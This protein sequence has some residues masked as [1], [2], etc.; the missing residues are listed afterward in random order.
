MNLE[1]LERDLWNAADN[2]RANSSLNA[3]QYAMPVLGLI[4]LRH[5]YNR[6]LAVKAEIEPTLPKRGG[7]P[8]GIT[9]GDFIGK[10]AIYLP[11]EAHYVH[12]IA[13]PEGP[14]LAEAVVT[15]MQ[16]IEKLNPTLAGVLP[17]EYRSFEPRVLAVLL[18][19]FNSDNLKQASGNVLAGSTSTS[20]TSLPRPA[21]RK[22]ASSSPRLRWCG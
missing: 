17:K 14:E 22:A 16:E 5:A 4:F 3:A 2:L 9:P 18:K 6:F 7:K 13:Q 8:R 15:A 21:R 11:P 20:S 1:K 10:A 12:L 19:T